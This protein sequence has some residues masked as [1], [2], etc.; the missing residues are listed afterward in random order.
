MNCSKCGQEIPEN[1]KFCPKCG[2]P[3]D[4]APVE[5]TPVVEETPAVEET[6]VAEANASLFD[7]KNEPLFEKN[8]GSIF[9]ETS[10]PQEDALGDAPTEELVQEA[11][12]QT[13]DLAADQQP[14][15]QYDAAQAIPEAPKKKFN[16]VWLIVIGAV[17]L[18]G[19]IVA[20]VYC[21]FRAAFTN[22]KSLMKNALV[23]YTE[24]SFDN[25]EDQYNSRMEVLEKNGN[26]QVLDASITLD[27]GFRELLD[28]YGVNAD[29]LESTHVRVEAKAE[30]ES[31]IGANIYAGVNGVDVI[32]L[33]YLAQIDDEMIY[34][35]IPELSDQYMG[36]DLAELGDLSG[37]FSNLDS[38][39]QVE[40]ISNEDLK[41]LSVR[42]V[43]VLT[44][45]LKDVT[46][47][48]EELEVDG[49]SA[50]YYKLTATIDRETSA[51]IAIAI[52]QE[53]LDD[54]DLKDLMKIY[55]DTY[56]S[57]PQLAEMYGISST[58]F[59]EWYDE[60][61]ESV[62]EMVDNQKEELDRVKEEG[63]ADEEVGELVVY[64][65]R[66]GDLKGLELNTLDDSAFYIY[67]PEDGDEFGMEIGYNDGGSD[68]V[69]TGSGTNSHDIVDGEFIVKTD[70]KDVLEIEVADYDTAAAEDGIMVGTF[71]VRAGEDAELGSDMASE[72]LASLEYQFKFDS[73]DDASKCSV[74]IKNDTVSFATI[75]IQTSYDD[76]EPMSA[77]SDYLEISNSSDAQDYVYSM[78][79]TTLI[80]KLKEAGVP[81]KYV[82][83]LE[84]VN[85]YYLQ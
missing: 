74:I 66:V 32:S 40:Q 17:I 54:K 19:A 4:E 18:V 58:D 38:L 6:P 37:T 39:T 44:D 5:E 24:D 20:V 71:T 15:Y 61:M 42:Y 14:A 70:D 29:W 57:N 55:F 25:Y 41:K 1:T 64:V 50:N 30:E 82:S 53:I 72:M 31:S 23:G 7:D 81:D 62:E 51:K 22:P 75:D 10:A 16:K 13:A 46:K 78:D 56:G 76:V 49:V 84:F 69:I 85:E 52:G 67:Y 73:S 27:D 79:L 43:K 60:C 47:E 68:F 48:K 9:E 63:I 34:A 83:Q 36:I 77:P 21:N 33:L 12:A 35:Q 28:K 2:T 26:Q 3:V 80:D 59:D 45:Q 11:S 8:E 65:N